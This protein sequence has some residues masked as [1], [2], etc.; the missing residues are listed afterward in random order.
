MS[1]VRAGAV[2]EIYVGRRVHWLNGGKRYFG[3]FLGYSG[4]LIHGGGPSESNIAEI[5]NVR[6][7]Q[8]TS[9]NAHLGKKLVLADLLELAAY[10][11]PGPML[12]DLGLALRVKVELTGRSSVSPSNNELL[13]EIEFPNGYR[14]YLQE[15]LLFHV[16]DKQGF[17]DE[18]D[19]IAGGDLSFDKD[20]CAELA[21]GCS[22]RTLYYIA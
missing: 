18:G 5:G 2:D 4:Q 1:N 13:Y 22:I 12:A 16:P 11:K 8:S 20:G 9:S 19:P 7:E 6:E 17:D 15:S 3:T 14:L 21:R 10:Y